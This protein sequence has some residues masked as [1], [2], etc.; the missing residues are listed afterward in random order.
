MNKAH[1]LWPLDQWLM[2]AHLLVSL[3]ACL[4]YHLECHLGSLE[5]CRPECLLQ[6][7]SDLEAIPRVA[8]GS[9]QNAARIQTAWIPRC[10]WYVPSWTDASW[11]SG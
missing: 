3:L 10:S 4:V 9:P 6:G 7:M 8:D 11:V 1:P 2:L 5:A